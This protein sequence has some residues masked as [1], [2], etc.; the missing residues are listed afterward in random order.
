MGEQ[1]KGPKAHGI[2]GTGESHR[3]H[4]IKNTDRNQENRYFEGTEENYGDY[5]TDDAGGNYKDPIEGFSEEGYK[6][7]N[8]PLRDSRKG[9]QVTVN[10]GSITLS[11]KKSY[12]FV[13]VFDA[14]GFNLNESKG[15]S[16]V[17]R[18]NGEEP[19]YTAPLHAGDTIEIYWEG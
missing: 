13:D 9:I 7:K 6:G 15:R 11:G 14:I 12:I 2:E 19:M 4:Y 1:R 3:D 18:L 17:M 5:D 10:G 16:V 8:L